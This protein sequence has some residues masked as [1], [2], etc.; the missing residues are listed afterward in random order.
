MT[1]TAPRRP[2]SRRVRTTSVE[3]IRSRTRPA[4]VSK[5]TSGPSNAQIRR[6]EYDADFSRAVVSTGRRR[7]RVWRWGY[8][9]PVPPYLAWRAYSSEVQQRWG[10]STGPLRTDASRL[11][12]TRALAEC[13]AARCKQG[14]TGSSPVGSTAGQHSCARPRVRCRLLRVGP[15]C[16]CSVQPELAKSAMCVL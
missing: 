1:G 5:A 8:S 7:R 10:C 11:G 6:T 15:P 3:L 2:R 16:G 4:S 12:R 9:W 13:F 14:V